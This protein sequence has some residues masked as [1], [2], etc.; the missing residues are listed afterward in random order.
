MARI[1]L[2]GT[3]PLPIEE[4]S[5]IYSSS[6]RTWQLARGL[7]D[8][9]HHVHVIAFRP[10]RMFEGR[11]IIDPDHRTYKEGT[12]TLD[13][14]EEVFHFRNRDFL[15]EH[16]QAVG[17]ELLVGVNAFPS[18]CAAGLEL[19]LPFWADL[20]GF[21]MGEVQ[22][23]AHLTG[24]DE[25]IREGWR[26]ESCSLFRADVF[27][28]AS[29]PQRHALIGELASI[30]RLRAATCGYE[31]IYVIPVGRED[32]P[33]APVAC[34]LRHQLGKEAFIALWVGCYNWQFDVDTLFK[35]LEKAMEENPHIHFASSGGHVDG[36]NETTFARF[37]AQV[38]QSPHRDR[39]HFLGW[40]PWPEFDALLRA[41]DV[42]VSMD[43]PCYETELGARNRL[44]EMFRVGLPA[45]TT[46]GPEISLDVSHRGAGWGV[47]PG[48]VDAMAQALLQAAGNREECRQR[49]ITARNL[50]EQRY[51]L[52]ASIAPLLK[53]A[54]SPWV[55]PD[56]GLAALLANENP[57]EEIQ[58][59]EIPD[60]ILHCGIPRLDSYQRV[61][62]SNFFHSMEL[63]SKRFLYRN[64]HHLK[65]VDGRFG[66]DPMQ[67]WDLSWIFLYI[68]E[69]VHGHLARHPEEA[70]NLLWILDE[71]SFLPFSLKKKH[72]DL[73]VTCLC[74]EPGLEEI[75][76]RIADL[77]NLLIETRCAHVDQCG[78]PSNS[79]DLIAVP[80]IPEDLMTSLAW[81]DEMKKLLRVGGLLIVAC[82][83]AWDREQ[84]VPDRASSEFLKAL[85]QRFE[86]TGREIDLKSEILSGTTLTQRQAMELGA[87]KPSQ[88]RS[89]WQKFQQRFG[90]PPTHEGQPEK[91]FCCLTC[92]KGKPA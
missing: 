60:L 41:V 48:D 22:I 67:Q 38:Q 63:E 61:Q 17:T 6:N 54:E 65:K 52:E 2:L 27:S 53:W 57:A 3:G 62:E 91:A 80:Q 5:Y 69:H 74:P 82:D 7:L 50:F 14:V 9:G 26:E 88:P 59:N 28:A 86:V 12:F 32:L 90:F 35:G 1:T 72:P 44:T 76:H 77:E 29:H 34:E 84:R 15:R 73:Q 37:Q 23:R 58:L 68:S 21:G 30:G 10:T 25:A 39:Y 70:K 40:L 45:V 8:H 49:G 4:S 71:I 42:G 81:L 20:N 24:Q 92:R 36:H 18:A 83:V 43:I 89:I 13:S 66:N 78:F 46:I 11:R 51:T 64:H 31:F 85:K 75:C 79:F 87:C 47:P 55:A 19:D 16:I 33:P 56:R